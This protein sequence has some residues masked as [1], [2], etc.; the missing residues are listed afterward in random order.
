MRR[1][2]LVGVI[3][4]A[5]AYGYLYF[6]SGFHWA[7]Q[8]SWEQAQRRSVKAQL[9]RK[10]MFNKFVA[11]VDPKN[12]DMG[13]TTYAVDN[14]TSWGVAAELQRQ[15]LDRTI[16]APNEVFVVRT[17]DGLG[18][19]WR[20][21]GQK[22]RPMDEF[23]D[24]YERMDKTERAKAINQMILNGDFDVWTTRSAIAH[25]SPDTSGE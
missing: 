1:S 13:V 2:I 7:R 17:S 23:F 18:V 5:L 22:E 12:I 25:S 15:F 20:G 3:F 9:L 16:V 14:L 24:D 6:G 21:P 11:S 8:N 10:S 4:A 19:F